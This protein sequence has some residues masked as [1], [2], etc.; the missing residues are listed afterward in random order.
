ME[1]RGDGYG[2]PNNSYCTRFR[3]NMSWVKKEEVRV[4]EEDVAST[5]VGWVLGLHL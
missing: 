3:R 5:E 2:L 1:Y 4:A